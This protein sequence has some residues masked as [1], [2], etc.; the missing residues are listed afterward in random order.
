MNRTVKTVLIVGAIA[1]GATAAYAAAPP[2]QQPQQTPKGWS[3]TTGKD[4][5]RVERPSEVTTNPDG[6]SRE[7]IQKGRCVTIKEKLAS[8]AVKTSTECKPS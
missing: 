5:K 3:W 2:Q 4:G 6:S 7:V 8:G 1:L